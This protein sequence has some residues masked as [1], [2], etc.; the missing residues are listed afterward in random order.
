MADDFSVERPRIAKL[1]ELN[2]RPWRAQIQRLLIGQGLW[3]VVKHGVLASDSATGSGK[4][5]ATGDSASG[6][7]AGG[8]IGFGA[9]EADPERTVQKDAKASTIIMGYCSQG[10]LQHVLLL[11]TAKEQWE[12]LNTLYL[13]LGQ[14]QLTAKVQAFIGYTIPE[15]TSPT[16]A[17]IANQLDTIQYEIS[18]ID[19]KETP[20]ETL[21]TSILLQAVRGLDPRFDPL[22]LQLEL[23]GTTSYIAIVA[24]L[25]EW[26]RKLGPRPIKETALAAKTGASGTKENKSKFQGKCFNCGIKGHR[27]SECRKPKKEGSTGGS[28][29]P[30]ATPGGG[31]GLS[32]APKEPGEQAKT[33]EE[34]NWIALS[35]EEEPTIALPALSKDLQ[36]IVDSGCSRH[37]TYYKEAF[38]EL[39]PLRDP[40]TIGTA[41]GAR[42]QAISEGEVPLRVIVGD[43][44]RTIL[45]TRVLYV[46]KLAGSLISVLQL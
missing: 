33:A 44:E 1:T 25:S 18:A 45:L 7:D 31:R 30:L 35:A 8:S 40:I 19:A 43:S 2:Y 42:I 32:P 41:N 24:R 28:T 36:W 38:S 17:E 21:K 9:I 15:G 16:V 11:E 29:G 13:P 10:A 12:A 34:R 5:A 3:T 14:Q 27:K 26:E 37:M 39:Y 4:E 23:S 22:I 46:P 6:G 20:S